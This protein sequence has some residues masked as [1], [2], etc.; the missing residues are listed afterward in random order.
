MKK[1]HF[2]S[3]AIL[4]GLFVCG[5][6]AYGLLH[7]WQQPVDA[8]WT[9]TAFSPA[10]SAVSDRVEVW[11]NDEPLLKAV[12]EERL[13]LKQRGTEAPVAAEKLLARVNNYERVRLARVP[14]LLALAA[15]AGAGLVFFL[16]GLFTPVIA[17]LH[18]DELVDLHLPT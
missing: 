8:Y 14:I 6:S 2:R 11:V 13:V 5:G 15:A 1:S 4:V 3:F 16:V 17:A 9:K 10:L 7:L 12:G 18:P